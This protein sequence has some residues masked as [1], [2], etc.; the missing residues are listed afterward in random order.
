M[1]FVKSAAVVDNNQIEIVYVSKLPGNVVNSHT[2]WLE[3]WAKGWDYMSFSGDGIS[4]SDF[5]NTLVEKNVDVCR[6]MCRIE[7]DSILNKKKKNTTRIFL[8]LMNSLCI[9]DPTFR[10][11]IINTD[12]EWQRQLLRE[13]CTSTSFHVIATRRNCKRMQ[14]YFNVLRAL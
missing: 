8:K 12:C 4:Y 14:R 9:L 11:P 7:L 2:E 10:P 5:L 3:T 13:M 1:Y 6:K